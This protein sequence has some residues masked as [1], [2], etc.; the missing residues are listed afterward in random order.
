[1]L[2]YILYNKSYK[3]NYSEYFFF[4]MRIAVNAEKLLSNR[5]RRQQIALNSNKYDMLNVKFYA[6][7]LINI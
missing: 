3:I 1:M 7:S 2:A 5:Y 6:N 4:I